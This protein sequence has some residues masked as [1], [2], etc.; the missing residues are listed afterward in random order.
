M[1]RRPRQK[2]LCGFHHIRIFRTHWQ[3]HTS[4]KGHQTRPDR[5]ASCK[6]LFQITQ[7]Q[8]RAQ[9]NPRQGAH[10]R[11]WCGQSHKPHIAGETVT[12][13]YRFHPLG[14][15][16]AVKLGHRTHRGDPVLMVAD[17]DG[18]RFT[19]PSWMT[20]PEAAEWTIRDVPR[21][22]RT[23]MSEL[24]GLVALVLCTPVSPE[25]GDRNET[26]NAEDPA[27]K[28]G[29]HTTATDHPAEGGDG[30]GRHVVGG[31]DRAGDARTTGAEASGRRQP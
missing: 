16:R 1:H 2:V 7:Y 29:A 30:D 9:P 5:P 13:F 25:S 15:K 20:D 22:S 17:S 10:S 27:E 19:I 23:A 8:T 12:V 26:S 18:R 28:A 3:L 21:L 4:H 24:H 31:P 11:R 6:L 14:G